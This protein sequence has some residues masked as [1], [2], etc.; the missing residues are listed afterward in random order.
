MPLKQKTGLKGD[1]SIAAFNP[2]VHHLCS[3]S[4]LA[5]PQKG[6]QIE[7]LIAPVTQITQLGTITDLLPVHIEPVAV[8]P[9]H[10]YHKSIWLFVQSEAAPEMDQSMGGLIDLRVCNPL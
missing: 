4:I 3:H 9:T 6:S 10:M 7:G 1:D 8:V 5:C 2:P